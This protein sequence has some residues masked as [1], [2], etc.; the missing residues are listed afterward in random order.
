MDD[1]YWGCWQRGPIE[2]QILQ[3]ILICFDYLLELD[4]KNLLLKTLHIQ[5]VE[6][7]ESKL[8]LAW[9][10]PSYFHSAKMYYVCCWRRKVII[11]L[12]QL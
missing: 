12:I 7:G 5:V 3:A 11:S 1:L 8:V 2:P 4:G 6:P 9:E 10:L